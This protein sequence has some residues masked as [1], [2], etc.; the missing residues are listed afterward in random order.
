MAQ[1]LQGLSYEVCSANTATKF[2][3]RISSPSLLGCAPLHTNCL[4]LCY[5]DL[6]DSFIEP[7][8]LLSKGMFCN[9]AIFNLYQ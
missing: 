4:L 2:R 1:N 6:W 3:M 5:E 7:I 8:K 9:T